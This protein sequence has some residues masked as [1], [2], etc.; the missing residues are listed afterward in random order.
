MTM[1][2]GTSPSPQEAFALIARVCAGTQADLATHQAIQT[3]LGVI[4][5]AI[6]PDRTEKLLDRVLSSPAP[7]S[8]E[9]A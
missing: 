5:V 3:A 6:S 7:P 9:G 2:N 8:G 4:G 1:T